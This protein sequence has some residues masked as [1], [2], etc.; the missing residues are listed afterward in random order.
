MGHEEAYLDE[1]DDDAENDA[2]RKMTIWVALLQQF[3]PIV[4]FPES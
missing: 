4:R 1:G 2:I 3:V